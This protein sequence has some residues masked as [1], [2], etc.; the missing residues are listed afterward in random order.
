LYIIVKQALTHPPYIFK[1]A[2]QR[3]EVIL[4]SNADG[5]W[6]PHEQQNICYS[7]QEQLPYYTTKH[8]FWLGKNNFIVLGFA[9]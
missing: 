1:T 4:V 3:W 6:F 7:D 2:R 8:I 5:F 9:V